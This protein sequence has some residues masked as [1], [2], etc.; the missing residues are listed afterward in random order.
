MQT[1]GN[2]E[3]QYHPQC[4]GMVERFNRTLK[5]IL[6]KHAATFGCQWDR[7]LP[8]V[9]WAYRNTPHESTG[10]KPSFLLFGID[11]RTPTE[12]A[13]L[14]PSSLYPADVSEY[15]EEL[16]LSVSSARQLAADAV[17]KAQKKYKKYY[18]KQRA[19]SAQLKVGEWVLVRFPQDEQGPNRKLSRPWHGPYRVTTLQDPDACVVKVYFPQDPEIRIHL[20]RVKRCPPGFPAGFYWYGGKRRGPGR[21]PR[22]V[23]SMLETTMS[24]TEPVQHSSSDTEGCLA[25]SDTEDFSES[26]LGEPLNT[27]PV[28]CTG[29]VN[30]DTDSAPSCSS[31]NLDSDSET[32]ETESPGQCRYPLRNRG[33]GSRSGRTL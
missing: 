19:E 32:Q 20:C 9:L 15:R 5:T 26:D 16:C 28:T 10:E 8:G 2:P 11:C 29:A 3:A 22:W 21:P 17:Q 27:D 12:A 6:R 1:D 4:D 25:N 33:G 13:Y 23:L 30:T 24:D 18:D 7:Y 31:D 14:P